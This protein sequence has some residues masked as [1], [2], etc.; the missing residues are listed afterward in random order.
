M[1]LSPWDLS[2]EISFDF[3]LYRSRRDS[4]VYATQVARGR[5]N[6]SY[7]RAT[8]H[9]STSHDN[10][11]SGLPAT[12]SSLAGDEGDVERLK[13][14]PLRK[15]RA[16]S[17][18]GNTTSGC[19]TS[20]LRATGSSLAG[21]EGDVERLKLP[22]LRKKRAHS[23]RAAVRQTTG[24]EEVSAVTDE[25]P[26]DDKGLEGEPEVPKP[27]VPKRESLTPPV[28]PSG[29]ATP[30]IGRYRSTKN[31][32]VL[33]IGFVFI[34]SAFRALQNLQ[35]SARQGR[36]GALVLTLIHGLALITGLLGPMVVSR[37]G[38]RWSIALAALIYPAWIASNLCIT[39]EVV[40]Y[41]ILLT[42]SALVG[43]A[44]SIAWSAQVCITTL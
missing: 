15:K 20:G 35:T 31:L 1:S 8:K 36:V 22:P 9:P 26:A 18:G 19:A 32:L 4:Y 21:D 17:V 28:S 37:I 25:G 30:L 38:P 2:A 29:T 39:G 11:T 3:S 6:A 43:V 33:S 34:F 16:H 23:Y 42:S 12:G 24:E 44:Q 41:L 27:E 7:R 14:P 5:R 10:T 40:Y 13:L